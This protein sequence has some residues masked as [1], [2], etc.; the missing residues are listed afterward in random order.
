MFYK[1]R[2]FHSLHILH[3]CLDGMLNRELT[4]NAALP[5]SPRLLDI[6]ELLP[7]GLS[8]M[9]SGIVFT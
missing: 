3:Q 9:E 7:G 8:R 1:L 5:T 2:I 6:S 4:G